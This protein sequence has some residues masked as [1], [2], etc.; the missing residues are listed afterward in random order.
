MIPSACSACGS[1]NVSAYYRIDSLP[2]LLFPVS[3]EVKD[4]IKAAE[5]RSYICSDCCHVFTS[6][7]SQ[8]DSALI[9]GEYYQFYPYDN[10]ESMNVHYRRPFEIFFEESI[11]N[12]FTKNNDRLSLLEVGC[13]SGKQLEFFEQFNIDS[14]GI[15]PSPL[16][17]SGDNK[18]IK[19]Y[20]NEYEFK[21]KYDIIVARFVLEHVNDPYSFLSKLNHDLSDRGIAFIQVPNIPEFIHGAM[22]LFLAHEHSQYFNSYS[23]AMASKRAGFQVNNFP[24][25]QQ[26]SIMLALTKTG[27]ANPVLPTKPGFSVYESFIQMRNSLAVSVKSFLSEQ[28]ARHAFYGSGLTLSW[29]LYDLGILRESYQGT[30]ID[31]NPVLSG[32][33][34]PLSDF[35]I[36]PINQGKI[37]EFPSVILTLNPVYHVKVLQKLKSEG[38]KGKVFSINAEGINEI[39]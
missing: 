14:Y 21:N 34:M 39:N 17:V 1:N 11:K 9:Y 29:L 15:D 19:G 7:L 32:R 28:K 38:Y 33:F 36:H 30:V 22:P 37:N 25:G 35:S 16:N 5:I 2:L 23:A 12:H 20:Y 18:I 8:E 6:P 10:L 3:R 31:D 27:V 24:T 13:S 4:S 26:Q